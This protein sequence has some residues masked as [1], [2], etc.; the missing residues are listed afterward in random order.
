MQLKPLL[1]IGLLAGGVTACHKQAVA[2]KTAEQAAMDQK[3]IAVRAAADQ[4]IAAQNEADALKA[5]ALKE[6]AVKRSAE[7]VVP[8]TPAK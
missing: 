7:G 1:L 2:V 6:A 5:A 8:A 3:A 4:K